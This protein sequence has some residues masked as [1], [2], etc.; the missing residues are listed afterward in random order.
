MF[1]LKVL[2]AKILKIFLQSNQL[3]GDNA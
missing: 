2:N 1:S 3:I